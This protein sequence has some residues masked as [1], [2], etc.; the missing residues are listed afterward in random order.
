MNRGIV[1]GVGAYV[2]WGFL[3]IYWKA[4]ERVDSLEILAHR[5]V[6]STLF[7]AAVIT[8]R[9]SWDQIRNLGSR[10]LARLL[11]AGALLAVNWATYIWAVN[12]GHIVESS[13]GYFINP[14]LNVLLGVV[15]LRERL[16]PGQWIAVGLAAIG[17]AYMTARVGSLPWI[18]LVLAT[19]FAM[20]ALLKKQMTSVGPIESLTIE[21]ALLLVPALALLTGRGLDGRGGFIAD[22]PRITMLLIL[23][24]L[25]TALPLLLFGAA[26]HRIKL[27]TIGLLQYIA[28]TLQF[29]IG[30]FMY[31]E[32]VGNR[33]PGF[34]LV[35]VALAIYSGHG[36]VRRRRENPQP[37]AV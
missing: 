22:G 24:G 17:V 25:A 20:Y 6:W 37:L 2:L 31:N 32:V 12:H 21:V 34:I 19:T 16:E 15:I 5:I 23:S 33:L 3:P 36:L 4:L 30:V 35:W 9:H 10:R 8:I 13:L 26:A 1:L 27:S 18:A 28:P 7:L 14:L 11:L 29:L